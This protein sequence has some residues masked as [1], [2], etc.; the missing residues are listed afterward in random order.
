[1]KATVS[2][3]VASLSPANPTLDGL[4]AAADRALYDAKG[5]GRNCVRG[6]LSNSTDVPGDGN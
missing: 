6:G 1:L 2:L 5:A 4:L 3:G